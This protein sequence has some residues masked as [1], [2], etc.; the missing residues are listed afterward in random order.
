MI[1][2]FCAHPRTTQYIGFGSLHSLNPNCPYTI[3]MLKSSYR[4]YV[5]RNFPYTETLYEI[6]ILEFFIEIGLIIN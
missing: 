2:Q 6:R 1:V 4:N 3:A 5:S